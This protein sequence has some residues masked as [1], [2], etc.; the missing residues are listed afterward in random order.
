MTQKGKKNPF[1]IKIFTIKKP[2]THKQSKKFLD[3]KTKNKQTYLAVCQ[4]PAVN[5]HADIAGTRGTHETTSRR[6][7]WSAR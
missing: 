7:L 6:A 1:N 2:L 4:E 5:A 3:S